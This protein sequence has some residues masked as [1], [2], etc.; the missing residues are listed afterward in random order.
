MVKGETRCEN[1]IIA[2]PG[3]LVK[4]VISTGSELFGD[5]AA[6]VNEV[7][8]G[9]GKAVYKSIKGTAQKV[10][11]SVGGAMHSAYSGA[12]NGVK[13]VANSVSE[14]GDSVWTLGA[15]GVHKAQSL[16]AK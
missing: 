2:A 15:T 3:R 12:K 9:A 6:K 13:G 7:V 4:T 1:G 8:G 14:I 16:V 10:S 11:S 5:A